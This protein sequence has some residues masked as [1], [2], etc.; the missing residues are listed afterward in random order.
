MGTES[1]KGSVDVP[2]TPTRVGKRTVPCSVLSTERGRNMAGEGRGDVSF[3]PNKA[4]PNRKEELKAGL[5][6]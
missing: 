6:T 3:L 2:P 5:E 4:V 1:I